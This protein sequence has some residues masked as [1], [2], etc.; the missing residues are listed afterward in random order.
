MERFLIINRVYRGGHDSVN[1]AKLC[2]Q[3]KSKGGGL[4]GECGK[5]PR[6]VR[7]VCDWQKWRL[8]WQSALK[9]SKEDAKGGITH[10]TL[11]N[12]SLSVQK[13]SVKLIAASCGY[14]PAPFFVVSSSSFCVLKR[15]SVPA[16]L[17]HFTNSRV[18]Q[19]R[20]NSVGFAVGGGAPNFD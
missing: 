20:Y 11:T 5:R 16:L 2:P 4:R 3:K 12:N 10:L 1:S 8:A 19:R 15:R 13:A 6:D 7:I 17:N 9:I 18:L 14:F